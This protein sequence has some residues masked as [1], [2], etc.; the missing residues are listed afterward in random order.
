A[1]NTTPDFSPDGSRIIF[2]SNRDGGGIYEMPAFGGEARLLAREGLN[3]KYSPDG[4]QIAYWIGLGAVASA[5]PG[6]GTVWV[7]PVAGGQPQ[8]VGPNFTAARFPIWSPDGKHLLCIGYTSSKAYEGASLDWWLVATNGGDAV[9][10][11]SY[12]ALILAGLRTRGDVVS[13]VP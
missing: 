10:T 6:S 3:P 7:V 11:G 5:V 2:R 12:E 9:N 4:S 8:R 1:G 13:G